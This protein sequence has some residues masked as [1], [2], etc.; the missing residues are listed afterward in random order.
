[1]LSDKEVYRY[2]DSC[3]REHT[4]PRTLASLDQIRPG[5]HL[6]LDRGLY[7]HHT[8]VET[9]D[10]SNGE[11]NV[12]NY[13]NSSKQLSQDNSSPPKNPGFSTVVRRFKL[14]NESFHVIK[15]E[16]CFDPEIVVSRAKSKL[17]EGKYHP[18]TNN[19]EHFALWCKTGISS[20][21]QAGSVM[22]A[23]KTGVNDVTDTLNTGLLVAVANSSPEQLRTNRPPEQMSTAENEL[24]NQAIKK[25]RETKGISDNTER[26]VTEKRT[27]L[28]ALGT[29]LVRVS[30]IASRSYQTEGR[31]Q[32][33]SCEKADMKES[34]HVPAQFEPL[35]V[36]RTWLFKRPK[37]LQWQYCPIFLP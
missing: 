31:L 21:E 27:P 36:T 6:C 19:C 5:D 12:I 25:L 24:S 33:L 30:E 9:V 4:V 11:V 17:G 7:W 10:K 2:T 23:V 37:I 16:T 13:S 3:D 35:S 26:N 8:I 28:R 14:K 22:D 32:N 18:L 34:A 15:H 20:S 29:V 1:M